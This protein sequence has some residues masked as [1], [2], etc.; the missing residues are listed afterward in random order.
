MTTTDI[1][2]DEAATE[3]EETTAEKLV[4][5][6]REKYQGERIAVQYEQ[7]V[8]NPI[9]LAKLMGVRPQ[10][11]YQDIRSGRLSATKHNNTQ[12]LVIERSVAIAYASAYLDRK[13]VRLLQQEQEAAA[14]KAAS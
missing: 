7:G 4:R 14:I 5:Q 6:L 12:K 10:M 8:I 3:V 11:V 1:N 13:A 2:T 9:E